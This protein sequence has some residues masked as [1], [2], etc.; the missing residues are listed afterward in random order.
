MTQILLIRGNS[1]S[2]K[3]SLATLLQQTLGPDT[4][5]LSQDHL[6]RTILYTKDGQETKTIPLLLSILETAQ[7]L[8][9]VIILEGIFRSDWYQPVWS[10]LEEHFPNSVQAYY[11]D[12]PFEETLVRHRTRAK[13]SEFGQDALE[14]WFVP[15]DYLYRFSERRIGPDTSLEDAL[16]LIL[17]DLG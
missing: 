16:N 10:Y 12:L 9:D 8:S 17:Q 6:R 2:G 15:K 4:I 1:A 5:L 3:T 7:T 14:R 11:Y 13:A